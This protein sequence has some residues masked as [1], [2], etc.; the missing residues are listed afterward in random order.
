MQVCQLDLKALLNVYTFSFYKLFN[1]SHKSE[2]SDDSV[3][4]NWVPIKMNSANFYLVFHEQIIVSR[5]LNILSLYQDIY[6]LV[7]LRAVSFHEHWE[8]RLVTI[9][10]GLVLNLKT[11]DQNTF[12]VIKLPVIVTKCEILEAK[13][14]PINFL[15]RVIIPIELF[16][17]LSTQKYGVSRFLINTFWFQFN[18]WS[19]FEYNFKLFEFDIILAHHLLQIIYGFFL[20]FDLRVLFSEGVRNLLFTQNLINLIC[21]LNDLRW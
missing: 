15:F 5:W 13:R 18:F 21:L 19:A 16:G 12:I 20:Y 3:K 4:R 14:I 6:E 1:I 8:P 17:L 2:K 11:F 9:F 7:W 10:E